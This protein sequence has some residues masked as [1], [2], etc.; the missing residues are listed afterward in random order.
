MLSEKYFLF[1][2]GESSE[3]ASR[4][5]GRSEWLPSPIRA[6]TWSISAHTFVMI[7]WMQ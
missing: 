4:N 3:R 6:E 5:N 7:G 2:I 1:L